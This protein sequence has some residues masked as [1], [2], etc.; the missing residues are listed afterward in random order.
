MF[1]VEDKNQFSVKGIEM[2]DVERQLDFFRK[3]FPF[4]QLERAAT[5]GDGIRRLTDDETQKYELTYKQKLGQRKVFKF[6]PASGA[7][8]RMFKDL[9]EFLQAEGET[10]NA[11]IKE[12]YERL[13]DFAFYPDLKQILE[14]QSVEM[15]DKK[16]IAAAIL[17]QNGLNYG[18]LPKGMLLFHNYKSDARTA[19]EEHLAEGA[20]YAVNADNKVYL[21]FTVSP[22]H[23]NGFET[24]IKNKL[25]KY[26]EKFNLN[27][28]ISFSQ[29]KQ[30]TDILA[31]DSD[32]QPVRN[33]DGTILFRPGGHGALLENLNDI[34][35]DIIF[36]K[37]IDNVTTDHLKP[38]TIKYKKALAGLL[39]EQ[40]E[41]VSEYCKLLRNSDNDTELM[42]TI[43][44]YLTKHLSFQA[45][46]SIST[47]VANEL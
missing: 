4:L 10:E 29:Q 2:K 42:R 36:I 15:S 6:V 30:S 17:K 37:N 27:Y 46:P 3:G 1:T 9:F 38:Q 24:L 41:Q 32:N 43:L 12:V 39:I 19:L 40:H 35:A 23:Q 31:V 21:H 11:S 45:P 16:K 5:V 20:E 44:D 14:K 7:A 47:M 28:D 34:D 13:S 22:E 18:N 26:A 8:T 25:Q 33:A